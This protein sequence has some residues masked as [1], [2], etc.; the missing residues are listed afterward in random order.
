MR[1]EL[2]SKEGLASCVGGIKM[3]AAIGVFYLI[4][5]ANAAFNDSSDHVSQKKLHQTNLLFIMFDD[6]RTELNAY[7]KN[8]IISPNFDR[9]A[10]RSVVFDNA[11]CQI[12]VCN[13]SRDSLLTGLRP[14][15]VGTYGFQSSYYTYNS[16]MIMPTRLKRSGYT[17]EAYGK[18]RHWDGGDSEVWD[19]AF[20]GE[21]YDYQ[22]KEWNF[23]N[24]SV[25][26]DKIR[27]EETFP[28]HI[29]AS[30]AIDAIK[31]L[32][33]LDRF[34]MVAIGFKMPHLAMHV[35][36][37]YY[38]MYRSQVH[39]WAAVDSELRF[40][41][42]APVVAYRCC[43]DDYKYMRNE[44]ASP[45]N[46]THR[47]RFINDTIPLTVHQEMMWG[48]AA[49]ITFV[50]KQLGRVLD[51]I[52]ALELWGNLTVVLTA[53][54]GMHNGEK[55]I[56]YVYCN[57]NH[58]ITTYSSL[59]YATFFDREKWTLFDESTHV[60]LMIAHPQSP[61]KGQH[62][63]HPV[64]LIDVFPTVVD[65]LGV[66]FNKNHVYGLAAAGHENMFPSRK[67]IPLQGKSLAPLVLGKDFKY[68]SSK[69]HNK[70]I[71]RGDLMPVM[72]QTFALSQAWRCAN[73]ANDKKDS[74]HDSTISQDTVW[75]DGC[76]VDVRN[77]ETSLMGY[78]MRTLDF[79]YTMYIPF[80]RPG[81]LPMW[82]S[83]IF[84]EEF[85]DHR[86]G[87]LGDLGHFETVNLATDKNY[88][89]LLEEHRKTL[90]D[91]LWN[92]VVYVNLSRTHGDVSKHHKKAGAPTHI[93]KF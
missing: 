84:S 8:G 78:S 69:T 38:D 22:A 55:G 53:D 90:R 77:D 48:Y 27:A 86:K 87:Y 70:V 18:I 73:K 68:R 65:L 23:M 72:N 79:R 11:Y 81:H 75:W 25:M 44:G 43:A 63:T 7:G 60:P 47:L 29:F 35:P 59:P 92:E 13:P 4:S 49:L 66:P 50:D 16:H 57:F 17:T 62:Y 28:D 34:F 33:K 83:P 21:W 45:S 85:Y 32:S 61:F 36:Y 52:D 82:D 89:S 1:F 12:A 10:A 30:K 56:W 64:E 46:S 80:S 71:F 88:F 41:P 20:D 67:F 6:L 74:R 42:T 91:F 3:L 5:C 39:Q 26:P 51:A 58:M 15:T 40:P 37:K 24:S 2:H 14:D 76:G 93:G 54:H 31:R 19:V 9:L